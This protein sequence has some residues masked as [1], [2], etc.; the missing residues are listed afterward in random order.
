MKKNDRCRKAE[1]FAK[2]CAV[3][4]LWRQDQEVGAASC[5]FHSKQFLAGTMGSRREKKR[6]AFFPWFI[7][8]WLSLQ[9][10]L[11]L[12]A[13]PWTVAGDILQWWMPWLVKCLLVKWKEYHSLTFC[14]DLCP[15][16]LCLLV[17][18]QSHASFPL[19]HTFVGQKILQ[20]PSD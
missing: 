5:C 4:H 9:I 14:W 15:R 11:Y 8:F 6:M 20:S 19:F 10:V 18:G 13:Q 1:Q 16:L 17:K 7:I 3:K 2:V 12:A